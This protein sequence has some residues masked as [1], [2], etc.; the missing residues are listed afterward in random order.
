MA[1]IVALT[2]ASAACNRAG[3]RAESSSDSAAN[4]SA[5]TSANTAANTPVAPV[6]CAP[7]D[8]LV[9]AFIASADGLAGDHR[10][11]MVAASGPRSGAAHEG[12][13]ALAKVASA[14]PSD[15]AGTPY[16]TMYPLHG[17]TTLVPDSVGAAP[18]GPVDARDERA[19]GVLVLESANGGAPEVLLRLGSTSN[20]A[21]LVA[22]DG[23]HLV[24][25]VRSISD[26]RFTGS[27]SSGVSGEPARAASG[28]FC[29]ER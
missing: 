4:S 28:Y 10:I 17:F 9:T 7:S 14:R 24:L 13:L 26:G 23:S 6:P 29:A 19:P 16:A 5:N 15:A 27:W 11:R 25:R 2:F 18:A 3:T 1:A 12:T 21:G 8:S 20:Q 22:F